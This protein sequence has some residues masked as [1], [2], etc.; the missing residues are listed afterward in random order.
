MYGE[1]ETHTGGHNRLS[2]ISTD[3]LKSNRNRVW[4]KSLTRQWHP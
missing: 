3:R 4:V 1:T 2:G